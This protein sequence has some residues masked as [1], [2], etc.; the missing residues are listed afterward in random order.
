MQI[1]P[2]LWIGSP[3]GAETGV[4]FPLLEAPPGEFDLALLEQLNIGQGQGATLNQPN[5]AEKS[6]DFFPEAELDTETENDSEPVEV[7]SSRPLDAWAVLMAQPQLPIQALATVM[8]LAPLSLGTLSLTPTAIAPVS[9]GIS[10]TVAKESPTGQAVPQTSVFTPEVPVP[11]FAP[12][13]APDSGLPVT[14]ATVEGPTP[15][16]LSAPAMPVRADAPL[17]PSVPAPM[18]TPPDFLPRDMTTAPAQSEAASNLDKV[19]IEGLVRAQPAPSTPKL[20]GWDDGMAAALNLVQMTGTVADEVRLTKPVERRDLMRQVAAATP[21]YPKPVAP[22]VVMPEAPSIS[23]SSILTGKPVGGANKGAPNEPAAPAASF[24]PEVLQAPVSTLQA[25][26]LTEKPVLEFKA[27]VIAPEVEKAVQET[28]EE[29][30]VKPIVTS[31]E[32]PMLT[33]DLRPA[34]A[35]VREAATVREVKVNIEPEQIREQVMRRIEQIEEFRPPMNLTIKMNPIDLGEITLTVRTFGGES[36]ATLNSTHN[37]VHQA[38]VQG[39][40]EL[41]QVAESKGLN[42]SSFDLT[43]QQGGQNQPNQANRQDFERNMNVLRSTRNETEAIAPTEV[44]PSF[45]PTRAL[46]VRI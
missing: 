38:L 6:L 18:P 42:L 14:A 16:Q 34:E 11:S 22:V 2:N 44:I 7:E 36:H 46:D 15:G 32:S 20:E 13:T 8:G 1:D 35:S 25:S 21:E 29:A 9:Q 19:Q 28:K 31:N 23:E 12:I 3:G 41:M 39:K 45:G 33:T 30:A 37:Q 10:S 4:P 17:A 24:E 27:T 5:A 43:Q 26:K 40:Q